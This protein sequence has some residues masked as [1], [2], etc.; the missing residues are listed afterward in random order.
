MLH[1]IQNKI[2]LNL[3]NHVLN[4]S[5]FF[6]FSLLLS[7]PPTLYNITSPLGHVVLLLNLAVVG[8]NSFPH[9]IS[10]PLCHVSLLFYLCVYALFKLR[11]LYTF[12]PS[13]HNTLPGT[14]PGDSLLFQF[15]GA[16]LGIKICLRRDTFS[17]CP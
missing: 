3:T 17:D 12:L 16:L 11:L 2:Y 6:P 15:I 1:D 10:H 9:L 14:T 13:P 4:L 7:H 8:A 5:Q